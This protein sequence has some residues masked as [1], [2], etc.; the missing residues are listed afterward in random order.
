MERTPGNV[1]KYFGPEIASVF[2]QEDGRCSLKLS[3]LKDYNDPYEFF[4]T[5]NYDQ[6]PEIL[7]YYNEMISMVIEHPVTCF[8]KSPIS[9]P[10]WAHYAAN[11]QGFVVEIDEVGLS[12]WLE[13]KMN[14]LGAFGDIDYQDTPHGYMQGLLDKAFHISK[15]RHIGWLRDAISRAAYFTKQQCWSYEE[16]RRLVTSKAAETVI[17]PTLSLLYFPSELVKAIIVGAKSTSTTKANLLETA[18]TIGCKF[19]EKRIGRSTTTPFFVDD[20]DNT[21]VFTPD[22]IIQTEERCEDCLEPSKSAKCSWC[23]ISENDKREAAHRNTFH[24]LHHAGILGDYL[25]MFNK[26][27]RDK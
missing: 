1:Y 11:S 27:G 26:V 12:N 17:S 5:I 3:Y 22:G 18:A 13:E 4:L 20:A 24:I 21:Y 25:E 19:Y 9:T 7:A 10:M 23:S 6:G 14:W 15:F 16:E 8:S 2:L